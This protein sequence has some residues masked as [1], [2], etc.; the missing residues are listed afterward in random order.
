[1]F[2]TPKENKEL[3]TPTYNGITVSVSLVSSTLVVL[4]FRLSE[5]LWRTQKQKNYDGKTK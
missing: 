5:W 2:V 1:M 4:N 3:F